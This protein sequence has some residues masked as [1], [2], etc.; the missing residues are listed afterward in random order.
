MKLE[1]KD[2]QEVTVGRLIKQIRQIK[3]LV[4]EGSP[5]A[6][7]LSSPTGSGKTVIMTAL[8]ESVFYG[9]DEIPS[10]PEAVFLWLSDQPELNEQS[11]RKIASASNRL[12]DSDLLIIQPHFDQE[13]FDGGKVYF[14]N[15]QKLSKD[16]NLVSIKGDS[17][18]HT[19]WE[20]IKKTQDLLKDKFYLVI[21]E[22][23]RG[24]NQSR[25]QE[26]SARTIAQRFVLGSDEM[27]AIQLILGVSATPQRFQKLLENNTS[28]Q[29]RG[30]HAVKVN[31]ADV[32]ASGL[33]KDKIV[34]YHPTDKQVA[35]WSL[36]AAA[37]NQ[38]HKVKERWND[39][40]QS[41][42][43]EA[44]KP[45]L[46]I[47][48]EDGN[49]Q[50]IS[51]TS[52][53]MVINELQKVIGT[54]HDDEIAHSFQDDKPITVGDR[55]IRK[56]EASR[57][58]D[59][60]KVKIVLFKMSLT[61]GWDCPRAEVM[62][63]FRKA[64]DHTLIAQ[65]IGRMIRTPLAR[66]IENQDFLNS[67]SLYLPYFDKEGL[68]NVV[69]N[70]S[71]P[72]F[73]PPI[74]PIID[75]ITLIRSKAFTTCFDV[76][77]KLPNYRVERIRKLSHTRRLM[78]LA[79]MLTVIHDIDKDA[80]PT[81]KSKILYVL[82]TKI[83]Q[84]QNEDAEFSNQM[85]TS[86]E[87]SIQPVT[88]DQ[89]VWTPLQGEIEKIPLSDGNI[90]EIFKRA[91]QRLGEGLH[92]DYWKA[93]YDSAEPNKPKLE[94]FLA[95][96]RQAIWDTLEKESCDFFYELLKRNKDRIAKLKSSE[97]EK[98]NR[99]KVIAKEPEPIDWILPDEIISVR[100]DTSI[101]WQKHLYETDEGKFFADNT[102]SW[103]KNCIR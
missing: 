41:Q 26:S 24:M 102:S 78:G 44:V 23:H 3:N 96:Q 45:I 49:D 95:L 64:N 11:R 87:L 72:D 93:Y 86:K 56:L 18:N 76:L 58:Q 71:D 75:P 33:L 40:T 74:V 65:L 103:E 28:Y 80:L 67:V 6:I 20:T 19:I 88:V 37:A 42:N 2:F 32:I 69:K 90:E 55:K 9:S 4:K 94:L 7:I 13:T 98:Y 25:Q 79:R 22:A 8:I 82:K 77:E 47:Q 31:P 83:D 89:G 73:V 51:R 14:L 53:T 39:Y 97:K 57:I 15:T 48:V 12:N 29:E 91:G 5:Q 70:L 63:S 38:W 27:P 66:R 85:E 10:E 16:G 21:D 52:I 101:E 61:T 62:M 81:A 68:D 99:L 50:T 36:L 35:D 100:S 43:I 60:E 30:Q 1:L 84:L 59:D 54:I 17:R 46:V 92:I 34:L